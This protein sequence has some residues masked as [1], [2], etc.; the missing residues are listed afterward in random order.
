MHASPLLIVAALAGAGCDLVFDLDRGGAAYRLELD[1]SA[2]SR[3]L[4]HIPIMVALAP[5]VVDYAVIGDPTTDLAFTQTATGEALPFEIERWNPAGES[6]VWVRIAELR[7]G[8]RD[9]Q[10]TMRV[11]PGA[12]GVAAPHDV[13]SGYEL[14]LHGTD[15]R[16]SASDAYAPT[17]NGVQA[18]P[19]ALA[20]GLAF[21]PN[22]DHRVTFANGGALLGG[23]PK[24]TLELWISPDYPNAMFAGEPRVLDQG[25]P[26]SLGRLLP[27]GTT[28]PDI[29]FRFQI[30]FHFTQRDAY[31][32]AYVFP[33]T[34]THVAFT[35]D[36][37]NLVLYRNGV[38][39]DLDASST[40]MAL[41]PATDPF[42]LGDTNVAFRGTLDEVRI[43]NT[44]RDPDWLY[45][46]YLSMA[47][48]MISFRRG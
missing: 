23:W 43:S 45:A 42:V 9:E 33:R 7:A 26:L 24:F 31:P 13:W 29:P 17:F 30:D 44:Y 41:D 10:V 46:Q 21:T 16:N 11:G 32:N 6:I 20:D 47:R 5:S 40:P 2:S 34:W 36:G 18:A 37:Q 39:A 48:R 1:N 14:V 25:G 19:G 12:N 35:Y 28:N 38:F 22:S 8:V 15:P 3:D 4:A 27:Q